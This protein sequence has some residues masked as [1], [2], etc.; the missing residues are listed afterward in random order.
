MGERDRD[1][2]VII[3]LR[4]LLKRFIDNSHSYRS[5]S[6]SPSYLS[7]L[8]GRVGGLDNISP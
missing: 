6:S 8:A 2:R 3:F 4:I 1:A 5:Y 7:K